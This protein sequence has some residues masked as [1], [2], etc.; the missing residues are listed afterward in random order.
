MKKLF[1]TNAFSLN[2]LADLSVVNDIIVQPIN[3]SQKSLQEILRDYPDYQSA[4]GHADTANVF[5][6][7]IGKSIP[8]NRTTVVL[9]TSTALLVGQYKGERLAEGATTLPEGATI[10]W[11][12]VEL[13]G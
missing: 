11:V 13:L 6:S 9:D 1:V 8:M 10:Q 5:S 4:V 7:V 12:L 2:M 3:G